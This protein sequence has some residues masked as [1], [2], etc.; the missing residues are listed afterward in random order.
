VLQTAGLFNHGEPIRLDG[1]HKLRL[2]DVGFGCGD[3]TLYLT[4]ALSRLDAETKNRRA[5]FDSYIGITRVR[6]QADFAQQR[7]SSYAAPEELAKAGTLE[8]QLFCADAA[9]PTTWSPKLHEALRCE[10]TSCLLPQYEQTTTVHT[11]LLALDSLSHFKPSRKPLFDHAYHNLH[12]SIMAFDLL[13]S[14]SASL[15]DRLLLRIVCLLASA[16]FSNFVTRAEYEKML[17]NSGY[18]REHVEIRDI[19]EHVFSGISTYIQ[20][21]DK[22]LRLFGF[23]L[24][25]KFKVIGKIFGWWTG[26][27]VVR[28]IIVVA[29]RPEML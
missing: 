14:D 5:L 13:L 15:I 7:L 3:Q 24:G 6:T 25:N 9:D 8:V 11:W 22:E 16:P 10:P 12:A 28:G 26:G 29:R 20:R 17:V 18:S 19:S 1:C 4:K 23:S 27:G 2:V 21:R